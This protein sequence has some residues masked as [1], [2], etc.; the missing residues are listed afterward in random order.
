MWMEGWIR[1]KNED[2]RRVKVRGRKSG[3]DE[4]DIK[5]YKN[6]GREVA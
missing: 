2:K 1:E 3:C 4:K 6:K 5:E